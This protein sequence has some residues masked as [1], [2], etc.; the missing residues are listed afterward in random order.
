M[1]NSPLWDE[2]LARIALEPR[3]GSRRT[4]GSTSQV[5][6]AAERP[7]DGEYDRY[8]YLVGAVPRARLTTRRRSARRRRSRFDPCSSTRSSSRPIAISPRSPRS[9]AP[10]SARFASGRAETARALDEA[11]WDEERAI[12]ADFDVRAGRFV[13]LGARPGSRRSTPASPRRRAGS[14]WWNGWPIRASRWD[15]ALCAVTSLAP[16][17]PGFQPTR[18]WRGPDLAHP[19]LGRCSADSTGTATPS[20]PRQVRRAM[21]ELADRSGFWEHYSPVTGKGHGGAEFAWTAGLVLELLGSDTEPEGGTDERSCTRHTQGS[22]RRE[23]VRTKGG[24]SR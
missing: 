9:S 5:A 13:P 3:P 11:L 7:T 16:S 19:Q 21:L 20:S 22:T 2:A 14:G 10:T 15:D 12:Y 6:D 23:T 4:R 17:D 18:Y 24:T 1:D 8:V